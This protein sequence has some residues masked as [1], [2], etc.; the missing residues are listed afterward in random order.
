MIQRQCL[1]SFLATLGR[2]GFELINVT[3]VFNYCMWIMYYVAGLT[4]NKKINT[5]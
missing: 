2:T 5:P 4:L 3:K 1:I